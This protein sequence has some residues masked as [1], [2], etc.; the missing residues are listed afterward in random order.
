[1]ADG[2]EFVHIHE[3]S[4]WAEVDEYINGYLFATRRTVV[5]IA[6]QKLSD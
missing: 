3:F 2:K 6:I 4:S 5:D 1:M